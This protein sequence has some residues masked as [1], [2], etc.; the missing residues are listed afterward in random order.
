MLATRRR[1]AA[2]ILAAFVGSRLAILVAAVFAETGP[3]TNPTLTSGDYSPLLR[4]LTSWDGWWYLSVARDGYHTESIQ[5]AYHDY[6]FL[7]LYPTLVRLL[8][9]PVPGLSGLI[10]VALSNVAF[11]ASLWLLYLLGRRH[12]RER[13]AVGAAVLLAISPFSVVFSM[14]YSESL[15]LA[16]SLAAFLSAQNRRWWLVAIFLAL[17]GL[18]RLQAPLVGLAILVLL[19]RQDQWRFRWHQLSALAAPLGTAAFFLFVAWLTGSTSAFQV[20]QS[21]WLQSDPGDPAGGALISHLD[22]QT[23]V[24]LLV[25]LAPIFPLV[26]AR[27]DRLPVEYLVLPVGFMAI[28]FVSGNILSEARFVTLAF[29]LFWLVANRRG[30]GWRIGWPALSAT[31][32]GVFSLLIFA[33]IWPP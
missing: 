29:P 2:A 14:A 8:S 19:L 6:A 13:T 5:A 3:F 23:I 10:A 32:L 11:L 22:A 27:A 30:P 7:P 24:Q 1:A 21:L 28:P 16:L 12:F 9:F 17:A 18:T 33:G 31:L 25:F 26:Y 4:S 20:N 15:F